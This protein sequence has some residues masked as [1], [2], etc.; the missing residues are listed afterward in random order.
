LK[1]HGAELMRSR[2]VAR[3]VRSSGIR[4]DFVSRRRRERG[5]S[6]HAPGTLPGGKKSTSVSAP[7]LGHVKR[8]VEDFF[9]AR[10]RIATSASELAA[11]AAGLDASRP[12]E[13]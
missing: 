7:A 3:D 13:K 1:N 9:C 4:R 5:I 8:R 10:I 12:R 11:A 6:L 2:F